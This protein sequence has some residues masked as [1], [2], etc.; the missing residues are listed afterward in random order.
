MSSSQLVPP[1]LSDHWCQSFSVRLSPLLCA[2]PPTP[3][4]EHWCSAPDVSAFPPDSSSFFFFLF[5][6]DCLTVW[7]ATIGSLSALSVCRLSRTDSR[8]L[9]LVRLLGIGLAKQSSQS[10]PP[11][12][13]RQGDTC[14]R[15]Q[16]LVSKP[17][18]PSTV[19]CCL[20]G[21]C[22]CCY[23]LLPATNRPSDQA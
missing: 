11:P 5:F 15:H 16:H 1:T 22:C 18:F 20:N 10:R 21:L 23:L 8:F 17:Q 2:A 12:Q 13:T 7:T 4:S 19:Q 6:S 3:G 14:R 9:A